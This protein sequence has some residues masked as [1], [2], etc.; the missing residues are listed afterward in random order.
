[1]KFNMIFPY[2]DI[3]SSDKRDIADSPLV[4]AKRK[5]RCREEG[6]PRS[7]GMQAG[8]GQSR[9][10]IPHVSELLRGNRYFTFYHLE[11]FVYLLY[12]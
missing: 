4:G 12:R 1:M 5:F 10:N 11:F 8:V 9:Y 6:L 7:I 3:S 2:F